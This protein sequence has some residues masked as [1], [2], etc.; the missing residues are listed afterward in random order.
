M[1]NQLLKA[2]VPRSAGVAALLAVAVAPVAAAT[3]ANA[4][5]ATHLGAP[6]ARPH[7]G[8]KAFTVLH[9]FAGPEG[10]NPTGQLLVD[11]AYHLF[12]STENGGANSLGNV[13]ETSTSGSAVVT[14]HSFAGTDGAS[15]EGGPF[16]S[17]QNIYYKG[18]IYGVTEN[19]GA[20]GEGAV[21]AID[22]SGGATTI[23]H[24]FSGTGTDGA[25]PAARLILFTDGSLYG[26]TTS[27][28][29]G[30][31]GTIYRIS[32]SGF[33]SLYSFTGL[34]D[35]AIPQG[36]LQLATSGCRVSPYLYGTTSSGGTFSSGTIYAFNPKGD[37]ASGLYSFTGGNDGGAPIGDLTPDLTGTVYGVTSNGGKGQVGT[38]F[39]FKVDKAK[40]STLH[41]FV[42]TSSFTN[43]LGSVPAA[44]LN[45]SPRT[46]ALY[47]VTLT[48][49]TYDDGTVYR[50]SGSAFSVLHSFD[51]A[52]GVSPEGQVLPL[53]DGNVY[54][55][56]N[57]GGANGLGVLFALPD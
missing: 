36:G 42:T 55:T 52:D 25:Y 2:L 14:L 23:V 39:G 22:P 56:T 34:A 19:G 7:W 54:G 44:G 3:L 43:P 49:G 5:A 12:G 29:T 37:T 8:L 16:N 1:V 6:Q 17:L 47:G 46:G 53:P 50:V 33:E 41:S 45:F 51:G 13:Y 31:A 48:G 57:G 20:F 18:L 28:G 30:G 11:S 40:L 9:S 26:T 32:K 21:Y 10:A 38:V 4:P 15:P 24:S 35:G 27:G